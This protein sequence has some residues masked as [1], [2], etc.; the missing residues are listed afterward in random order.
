MKLLSLSIALAIVSLSL[1]A[2]KSK[3]QQ[4]YP[5]APA[6]PVSYAK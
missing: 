4:A 2:C 5:T 1:G 3:K 6:A